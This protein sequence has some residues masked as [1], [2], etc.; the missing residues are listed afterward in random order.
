MDPG[1]R[2]NPSAGSALTSGGDLKIPH[3]PSFPLLAQFC[4]SC[5]KAVV[6][7]LWVVTPWGLNTG[8]VYLIS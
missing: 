7:N 3:S 8:V 1:K 2:E 6:L 4:L 5:F